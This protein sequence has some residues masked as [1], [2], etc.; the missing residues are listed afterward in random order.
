M[1]LPERGA[2]RQ[3]VVNQYVLQQVV[4]HVESVVPG[5]A[6]RLLRTA[7]LGITRARRDP[8]METTRRRRLIFA[9][10]CHLLRRTT[11]HRRRA[12]RRR[13]PLPSSWLMIFSSR[14]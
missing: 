5:G 7:A 8:R 2:P 1:H 12:H 3:I 9:G 14:P 13:T 6:C 4:T 11:D 10:P